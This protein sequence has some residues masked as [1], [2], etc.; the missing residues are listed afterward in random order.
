MSVHSPV[1]AKPI[2]E[3]L[4]R[5]EADLY[6]LVPMAERPVNYTYE[7]PPGVPRHNGTY[8]TRRLPIH[9]A[10]AIAQDLS[11]DR[12]GAALVVRPT[13]VQDFYNEA[14]VRQVYYPEAERLLAE[15]TGATQALVFDH[16]VRN[17]DR[18]QQGTSNAKEPVKRVHNDF[19]AKSGYSRAHA[20]LVAR[21][22]ENPDAVLQQ[23]FAIVNVWRPIAAPVQASPLALCDAQT[24]APTDL[25]AGDLVYRDRIGETYAITYSPL[26]RWF[27]FPQMQRDEVVLIKCF[28]SATDGRA[29]FAAHTAFDDPTTPANA[30]ARESIELRSL[31]FYN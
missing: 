19:T 26:H 24:I 3:N 1:L 7:P 4:P 27:Y 10:R 16:N 5:V 22:I 17:L 20:E 30:P 12:E 25:V 18:A 2:F 23:R 8:E 28:D 29:R 31:I 14:E 11:L 15:V 21:G 13:A 9:N 6:Y